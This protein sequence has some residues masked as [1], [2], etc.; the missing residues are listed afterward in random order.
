MKNENEKYYQPLS[1]DIH[2]IPGEH[3][4]CNASCGELLRNM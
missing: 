3:N 1:L 2:P 4:E